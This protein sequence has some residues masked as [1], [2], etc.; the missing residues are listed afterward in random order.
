MYVLINQHNHHHSTI[1]LSWLSLTL[2][3]SRTFS[4]PTSSKYFTPMLPRTLPSLS[5][6]LARAT[7]THTD[8]ESGHGG[9][10]LL[11]ARLIIFRRPHWSFS[12]RCSS[13]LSQVK[14]PG[15]S[16]LSPTYVPRSCFALLCHPHLQS[17]WPAVYLQPH[18]LLT[19]ILQRC[20][21]I[22]FTYW[23]HG[24]QVL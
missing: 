15:H 13:T 19:F 2:L 4:V 10:N 17:L 22:T 5:C 1:P 3:R 11:W 6:R 21:S 8:H 18:S 14:S 16:L 9:S 24:L 23:T 12:A 7:L 20:L